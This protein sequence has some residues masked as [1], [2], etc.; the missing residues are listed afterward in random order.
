M[1]TTLIKNARIAS[2]NDNHE[3]VQLDATDILVVNGKIQ[4][5]GNDLVCETAVRVDAH[6][7]WCLPGFIDCHTHL[8]YGGNRAQEFSLRL[9]GVSYETISKQGGGIKSTV[10]ATRAL[11][12]ATLLSQTLRRAKRL[13]EEG[14]TTVEIKSGYGLDKDTELRMLDVALKVGELTNLNIQRTFLG[15]HALPPDSEVSAEEYIDFVCQTMIPYV[16]EHQLA[17]AVDVFCEKV[18]FNLAQTERVFMAAKQSN[19]KV[20]GHVE[21]LSDS[22]GAALAAKY[23]ALSVDH[24]EYLAEEDIPLLADSGTVAVLL[25]GAFYYLKETQLPPIDA[26]RKYNVPIAIS[27]DMNPGTSPIAS[28]LTCANMACVLF[29]LTTAEALTGITAHAALA[30]G[31]KNKGQI[32]TGYDA[33]MC[34]WDIESPES[35]VYE[36]NGYRPT[37]KWIGGKRVL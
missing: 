20:K 30:L 34:L 23:N 16:A 12:E 27:T 29:G 26:L 24:I 32:K 14:V 37:A 36:I 25:P 22:K 17:D 19:L 10:R 6:E 4:A 21:Q 35:L 13:A 1:S 8:V 18:G 2:S 7:Q 33:D 3:F 11:N 31:L 28:L 15:A 9:K 5:I